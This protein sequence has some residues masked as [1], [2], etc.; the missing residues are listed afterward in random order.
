[1]GSSGRAAGDGALGKENQALK[2]SLDDK[3]KAALDNLKAL[4]E[5]LRDELL[6]LERKGEAKMMQKVDDL[7]KQLATLREA[8]MAFISEEDV[9]DE[10]II[11][12]EDANLEDLGKLFKDVGERFLGQYGAPRRQVKTTKRQSRV[13]LSSIAVESAS[14]EKKEIG[15]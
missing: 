6:D 11:N 2:K 9:T 3:I 8:I 1:M 4:E 7:A 12:S 5:K 13:M 14:P 15:E 10:S